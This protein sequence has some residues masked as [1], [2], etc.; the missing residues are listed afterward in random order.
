VDRRKRPAICAEECASAH[1]GC[2]LCRC[3][4]HQAA[5]QTNSVY[6]QNFDDPDLL[7]STIGAHDE[8]QKVDPR[9]RGF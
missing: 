8:S 3:V 1:G 5:K 6:V 7:T 9:G 2:P 4:L